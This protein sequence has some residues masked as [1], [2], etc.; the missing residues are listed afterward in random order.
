MSTLKK[1]EFLAEHN[2]VAPDR[3]LTGEFA[4]TGLSSEVGRLRKLCQKTTSSD[5]K[6]AF[7]HSTAMILWYLANLSRDL[8]FD[9]ERSVENGLAVV[10]SE[11][12]RRG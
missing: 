3:A 7:E 12:E 8:N 10:S 6:A 9:F 11:F 5:S 4:L 2:P 1:F